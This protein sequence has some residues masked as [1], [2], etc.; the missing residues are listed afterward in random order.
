MSDTTLGAA[1]R[2]LEL[3]LVLTHFAPGTKGP[4]GPEAEGW[5]TAAKWIDSPARARA[6]LARRTLNLGVIHAPSGTVA[7]DVDDVNAT[8]AIFAEFGLDL[9]ALLG[10]GL[11]IRGKADRAKAL[12]RCA[13]PPAMHKVAWNR[14]ALFELRS[15]PV[16]DVL[17]PSLHPDGHAY[18]W[19][20]DPNGHIPEIPP[21]LLAFWRAY[22]EWR[23]PVAAMAPNA[24]APRYALP[25]PRAEGHNDVIGAFNKAH[26]VQEFLAANGYVLKGRRW[27]APGSSTG[28]PGVVVFD[29]G[30]CYSHHASDVL[31]D[32]HAHDAFDLF[33]LFEHQGDT[34]AAVQAAADSLGMAVY[35]ETYPRADIS[36][37]LTGGGAPVTL[38]PA[39]LQERRDAERAIP[40]DLLA[41]PGILG[42]I[43]RYALASAVLPVP[44]Y[45]ALTAIAVGSVVCARRYASDPLNNYSSLYLLAVGKSGTGKEHIKTAAERVLLGAGAAKLLGPSAYTSRSAI[46]AALLNQPQ[47]LAVFDE[48]GMVLDEVSKAKDQHQS[49]MLREL[50]E[51]W[52]RVHGLARL[53]QRA[54]RPDDAT[55]TAIERPAVS[56][57]A[58]TTPAPFYKALSSA[59]VVGGFLSRFVIAEHVGPRVLPQRSA[60]SSA[61]V[62]DAIASWIQQVLAP[63]GNL[64]GML[65]TNLPPAA[66]VPMSDPVLDASD[67]FAGDMLRLAARLEPDGLGEMPMRTR[68]IALRL[69]LIAALA[70][71]PDTPSVTSDVF[72]WAARFARA[73][74]EQTLGALR[75]RVAD[76]E[77]ERTRNEF[78]AAIRAAGERGVTERELGQ[79]KPFV[80]VKR[81][82]R[83]DT[84]NDLVAADLV[85][86]TEVHDG[87]RGRPR[88]AWVAL[89]DNHSDD[90]SVEDDA[91]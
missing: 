23:E 55:P 11:Q 9:D 77:S 53:P 88:V 37:L 17:P 90:A 62:P 54:G 86:K 7:L 49:G 40:G 44:V 83:L 8:R 2:Y 36:G 89:C 85:V 78:L 84:V 27:L 72:D 21:Q 47:H 91:A 30:K 58:M 33:R 18:A 70:D 10:A 56:L 52:G 20:A 31:A 25:S 60:S 59:Q 22:D 76:S 13:G 61:D 29:N 15:G 32:G 74:L 41:P 35:G 1:L 73:C 64:D 63:Q 12:Y 6:Q 16:Q 24:P 38:A 19:L 57:V 14:R 65:V 82:E 5:N 68:E 80:S 75:S 48:F 34:A 46:F 71:T 3:G 43:A 81:R 79:R 39:L 26:T 28:I 87:S 67:A 42:D 4:Q 51:L 69:A 66:R 45:A 50:M